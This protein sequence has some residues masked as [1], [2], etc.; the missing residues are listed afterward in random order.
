MILMICKF[1]TFYFFDSCIHLNSW[2]KVSWVWEIISVY[3]FLWFNSFISTSKMSKY[4]VMRFN[5]RFNARKKYCVFFYHT[6]VLQKCIHKAFWLLLWE[7]Y[8][9]INSDYLANICFFLINS[10][11]LRRRVKSGKV[12]VGYLIFQKMLYHDHQN[13]LGAGSK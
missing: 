10:W 3:F 4:Y 11:D 7:F 9:K 2:R 8:H 6:I 12:W 13:L 1:L 5:L